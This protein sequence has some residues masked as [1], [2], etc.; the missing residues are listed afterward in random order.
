VAEIAEQA[1]HEPA[2]AAVAQEV[3]A[4]SVEHV[5]PVPRPRPAEP[6]L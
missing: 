3:A 4:P 6:L 5:D 1:A 2:A